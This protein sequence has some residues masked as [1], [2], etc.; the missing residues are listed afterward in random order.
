MSI[1]EIQAK[2]DKTNEA[3]RRVTG[4]DQSIETL[5][6]E[7]QVRISMDVGGKHYEIGVIL[8]PGYAR[9]DLWFREAVSETIHA[10]N[11]I[12]EVRISDEQAN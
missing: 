6:G 10:I 4:H 12:T 9:N 5:K 1:A 7:V 3:L 11:S 8:M 2:L